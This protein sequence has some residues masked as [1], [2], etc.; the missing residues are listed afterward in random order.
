VFEVVF[1]HRPTAK[2]ES[3]AR[4]TADGKPFDVYT[5]SDDLQGRGVLQLQLMS[6]GRG[7]RDGGAVDA[8]KGLVAKVGPVT[9]THRTDRGYD[10]ARLEAVSAST[11]ETVRVEHRS[12]LPRGMIF[13]ATTSFIKSDQATVDAFLDSLHL[14]PALDPFDD[15]KS[16]TVRVRKEHGKNEAHDATD[17]FRIDMPWSAKVARI[18]SDATRRVVNVTVTATHGKASVALAIEEASAW[19]ALAFSPSKQKA[20]VET[21]KGTLAA[22]TKLEIKQA[23]EKLGGLPATRLDAKGNGHSYHLHLLWNRFQHRRYS[24]MCVDAPCDVVALSLKFADPIPV[25]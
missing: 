19:D 3:S 24:L 10:I 15:P 16:L 20:F 7:A 9:E 5:L 22:E 4:P 14:R 21:S 17:S 2:V 18:P 25:Q 1:P 12:D 6:L 23:S 11:G 8:V 13:V